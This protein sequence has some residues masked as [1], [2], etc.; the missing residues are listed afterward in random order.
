MESAAAILAIALKNAALYAEMQNEARRDA[1]TGLFNRSYFLRR[2][3]QDF[4]ASRHD[5]LSLLIIS[6]D[7]FR[8]YNELYTSYEGDAVLRAFG[9]ILEKR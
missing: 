1:L 9:R 5:K 2:I 8:L 4:E 7:D 6:F 3:R